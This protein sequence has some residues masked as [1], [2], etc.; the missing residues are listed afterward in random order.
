MLGLLRAQATDLAAGGFRVPLVRKA[1][2]T[3]YFVGE[4]SLRVDEAG[5]GVG[6]ELE[7]EAGAGGER[8]FDGGGEA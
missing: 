7:G 2:A 4:A 5:A 1:T 3:G 8:G 6:D